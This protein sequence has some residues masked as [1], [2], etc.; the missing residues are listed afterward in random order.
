LKKENELLMAFTYALLIKQ[1]Y[2]RQLKKKTKTF[3]IDAEL[4]ILG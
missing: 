2:D 1:N 3:S 4:I